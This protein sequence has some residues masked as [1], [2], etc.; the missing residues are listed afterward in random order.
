MSTQR[1][2]ALGSLARQG[3]GMVMQASQNPAF[4]AAAGQ[5]GQA[6]IARYGPP[7]QLIQRAANQVQARTGINARQALA[8]ANRAAAG[9]FG[10][11]PSVRVGGQ[12]LN[13]GRLGGLYT[14]ARQQAPQYF[15]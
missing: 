11:I 5:L 3:A 1:R 12:Q 10:P 7:Q 6:A 2:S 4:R 13:L 15:N 9:Q 14:Q 8:V